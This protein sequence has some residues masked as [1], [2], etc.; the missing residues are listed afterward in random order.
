MYIPSEIFQV[1]PIKFL[2]E[3]MLMK[4]GF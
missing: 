2:L 3:K 1:I 4:S